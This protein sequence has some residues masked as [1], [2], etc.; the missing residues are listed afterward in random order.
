MSFVKCYQGVRKSLGR[1]PQTKDI[2]KETSGEP[3]VRKFFRELFDKIREKSE[4]EIAKAIVFEVIKY[5]SPLA[6]IFLTQMVHN[7]SLNL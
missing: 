5:G 1:F 3:S 6:T 4:D 2:I 7:L